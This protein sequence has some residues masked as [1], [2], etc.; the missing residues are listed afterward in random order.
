MTCGLPF[1]GKTTLARGAAELLG[2]VR[3]SV[4]DLVPGFDTLD[5]GAVID[6]T[7]WLE[8]YRQAMSVSNR[9][10]SDG[11]RVVFDSVGH[12]RKNRYRMRRLAERHGARFGV[13]WID[14]DRTEA[15]RR[16]EANR[17]APIRPNVP[18]EGFAEIAGAFEAP[19]DDETVVIYRPDGP[20][21]DW[22]DTTLRAWI[23]RLEQET[24]GT[25]P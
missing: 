19:G 6:S 8:A 4:D 17:A 13:V 11:R 22:I 7:R 5:G 24:N 15:F 23:A 10:L 16:L 1:S 9:L 3:V 14:V 18:H 21:E 20:L 25:H 12:T 2:L